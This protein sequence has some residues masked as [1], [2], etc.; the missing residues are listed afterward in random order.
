M[1]NSGLVISEGRSYMDEVMCQCLDNMGNPST[2]HYGGGACPT[3]DRL[4]LCCVILGSDR[5]DM[6]DGP[7][8]G[9][10]LCICVTS[11]CKPALVMSVQTSIDGC[12]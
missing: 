4:R 7:K 3:L 11:C 8:G 12:R 10:S 9:Y 6:S 5:C 2:G 1:G